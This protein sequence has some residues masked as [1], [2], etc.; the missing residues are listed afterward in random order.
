MTN[1]TEK[2]VVKAKKQLRALVDQAD[3]IIEDDKDYTTKTYDIFMEAY[4]VADELLGSYKAGLKDLT[5]A[6]DDLS[7]AIDGLKVKASSRN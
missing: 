4:D 2:K 5:N 3:E 6:Y 7:D 1:R